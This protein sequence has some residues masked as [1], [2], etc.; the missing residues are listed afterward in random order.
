MKAV[1]NVVP[2][3]RWPEGGEGNFLTVFGSHSKQGT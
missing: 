1:G 3:T 2:D